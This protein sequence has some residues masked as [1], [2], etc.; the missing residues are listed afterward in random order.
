M[1][2]LIGVFLPV[3]HFGT[4]GR[5]GLNSDKPAVSEAPAHP[6]VKQL[7]RQEFPITAYGFTVYHSLGAE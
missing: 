3:P 2:Q 1:V 7:P 4:G 6:A 5:A